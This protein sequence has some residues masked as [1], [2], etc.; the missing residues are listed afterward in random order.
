MT[1]AITSSRIRVGVLAVMLS[2][3]MLGSPTPIDAATHRK[4]NNA[5]ALNLTASWM[6]GVVPTNNDVGQWD[7]AVTSANTVFLGANLEKLGLTVVN[8][9]GP[10][11][12][13][14]G[15]TLTLESSDVDLSAATQ[16]L[17][18]NGDL[19]LGASQSWTAAAGRNFTVGGVV[20][21]AALLTLPDPGTVIFTGGGCTLGTLAAGN[22]A[23]ALNSGALVMAGGTLNLGGN[24]DNEGALQIQCGATFKQ[25]G[26]VVNSSCYTR[27]GSTGQGTL[28]VNGGQF[29]N[30]GEILLGYGGNGSTGYLVVSNTGTVSA[31]F[32]RAGKNGRGYINLNGGLLAANRIFSLYGLGSF[33]LNGGKLLVN[34]SPKNPYV[35]NGG[36]ILDTAGQ[37]V[38]FA[39][40]LQPYSG[41]IGEPVIMV[42]LK[43]RI[44]SIIIL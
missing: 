1:A 42:S 8:P 41:S 7:S 37:N 2:A 6:G 30:F 44:L 24:N 35:Q 4:A 21:G 33:T 9:G 14:A 27:V 39:S 5:V 3:G 20:S 32:L 17:T 38:T 28:V 23:L 10:V 13:N 11:T 29:N 22:N 36:A 31:N 40:N 18:A 15:N 34:G 12:L 43:S 16:D 25:T 19:A 26:V